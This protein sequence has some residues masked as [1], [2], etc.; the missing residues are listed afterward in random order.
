M[1]APTRFDP[2]PLAAVQGTLALDLQPRTAPPRPPRA[3]PGS[4]AGP[5]QVLPIDQRARREGEQWAGT[6]AQAVVEVVGGDRPSSQ[7]VRWTSRTV[8]EDLTRRAQLVA[9]AGGHQPGVAR[10]QPVRPQVLSVHTCFPCRDVL[11]ASVHVAYGHR[12]RA[13]AARFERRP[14]SAGTRTGERWLCTALQF[15]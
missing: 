6:F 3:R 15:A 10:V 9:R 1:A 13:L 4:S 8:H 11:E 5:G 2:V 12:S 14:G 7:L